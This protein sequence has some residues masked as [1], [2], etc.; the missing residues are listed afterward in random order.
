MVAGVHN[1]GRGE[2]K[3]TWGRKPQSWFSICRTDVSVSRTRHMLCATLM[4]QCLTLA[5]AI[6]ATPIRKPLAEAMA[7]EQLKAEAKG[8]NPNALTREA[9]D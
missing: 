3:D 9:L 2:Y 6:P 4:V 5:M 7:P 8:V 1:R